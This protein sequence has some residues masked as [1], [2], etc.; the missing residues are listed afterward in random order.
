MKIKFVYNWVKIDGVFHKILWNYDD[1]S[2]SIYWYGYNYVSIP[3]EIVKLADSF[4]NDSDS[5]SD[6]FCNDSI[7]F[8]KENQFYN[9]IMKCYIQRE[10]KSIYRQMVWYAKTNKEIPAFLTE[11][12]LKLEEM[13]KVF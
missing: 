8:K 7:Y 10:E 4:H 2:G 3:K 13:K 6:Y 1:R 5:M 12:L 11:R 9:E